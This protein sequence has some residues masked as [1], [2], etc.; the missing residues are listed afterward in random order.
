[1]YIS[2]PSWVNSI[3]SWLKLAFEA[4][5]IHSIPSFYGGTLLGSSWMANTLRPDTQTRSSSTDFLREALL[6]TT[7]LLI[8][9]STLAKRILFKDGNVASGVVVNSGGVEYTLTAKREVIVSSGVVR[10]MLVR[11][12]ELY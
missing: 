10:Y 2:Y 7:N 3:S 4:Q 8:Y 5:G 9:K 11:V 12:V 1:M 6:K